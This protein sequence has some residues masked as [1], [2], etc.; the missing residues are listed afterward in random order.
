SDRPSADDGYRVA[1]TDSG[2]LGAQQNACQRLDHSGRTEADVLRN[3]DQIFLHYAARNANV[4]SIGAVVEQQLVAEIL[5][6]APAAKASAT[7]RRIRRRH[8]HARLNILHPRGGFDDLAGQLMSEQRRGLD[9]ASVIA[10][11]K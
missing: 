1:V 4:L 11:A 9:H 8:P 10:P 2:L 5:L 7:G 6:A 3:R